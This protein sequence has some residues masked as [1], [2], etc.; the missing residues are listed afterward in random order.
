M[1][2]TTWLQMPSHVGSSFR[3]QYAY[4]HITLSQPTWHGKGPAWWFWRS[5]IPYGYYTFGPCWFTNSRYKHDL[6][7]WYLYLGCMTHRSSCLGS[8]GFR[9]YS[10]SCTPWHWNVQKIKLVAAHFVLH[11]MNQ[12]VGIWAKTCVHCQRSKVHRHVT[13]PL[14]HGHLPDHRFQWI[15]VDIFGPLPISEGKSYLFTIIDRYTRWPEAIPMADATASSCAFPLLSQHIVQ[16]AVPEAVT[17]KREPQF[18][19]AL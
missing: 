6:A 2:E 17:S 8:S 10:W 15:H 3:I 12:Q 4:P 16:F 1:D 18:N 14:Q 13:A 11:G 5:G 9:H 19:S 7:L